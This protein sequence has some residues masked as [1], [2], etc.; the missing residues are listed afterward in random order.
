MQKK[1]EHPLLDKF[2]DSSNVWEDQVDLRIASNTLTSK[3]V[4]QPQLQVDQNKSVK[5]KGKEKERKRKTRRSV[6]EK[7]ATLSISLVLK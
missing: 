2:Y 6:C 1:S 4:Q 3:Q 7:S 5:T